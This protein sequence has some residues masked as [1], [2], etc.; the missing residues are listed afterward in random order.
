MKGNAKSQVKKYFPS[1]VAGAVCLI[2]IICLLVIP[3]ENKEPKTI[4]LSEYSSVNTICELATLRSFY[5]NVA[6]YE[7][8]RM[9]AANSLMMFCFGRLADTQR[10]AT[11]SSG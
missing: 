8:N 5:H 4:N 3:N 2:I 11:N 6:M 7:K 1:I 9:V 10:S